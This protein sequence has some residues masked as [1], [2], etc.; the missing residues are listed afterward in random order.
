MNENFRD[1][2]DSMP[3]AMI[4]YW[5]YEKNGKVPFENAMVVIA[6]AQSQAKGV[7]EV[8]RREDMI[9]DEYAKLRHFLDSS[10]RAENELLFDF[11]EERSI[12]KQYRHP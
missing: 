8:R 1:M 3:D 6:K 2:L 12:L 10:L 11:L 5:R 9:I 4:D 7:L